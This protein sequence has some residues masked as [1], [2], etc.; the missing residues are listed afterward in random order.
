MIQRIIVQVS[1]PVTLGRR[2]SIALS[3]KSQRCDEKPEAIGVLSQA[4]HYSTEPLEGALAH[5]QD[6]GRR[7]ANF[8]NLKGLSSVRCLHTHVYTHTH[9]PSEVTGGS[10]SGSV[11]CIWKCH[12]RK[13]A[14][15]LSELGEVSTPCGLRIPVHLQGSG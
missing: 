9:T 7:R 5:H 3:N 2:N 15:W 10:L 11:F 14:V 4:C 1:T 8:K 6:Q 12:S 13:I